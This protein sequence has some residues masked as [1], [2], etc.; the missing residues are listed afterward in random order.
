[1]GGGGG[2]RAQ[3][4]ESGVEGSKVGETRKVKP[5]STLF[6][7][8]EHKPIGQLRGCAM[9]A[10]SNI[11]SRLGALPRGSGSRYGIDIY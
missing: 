11:G 4:A 10:L 1:M 8:V 3:G 5:F 2:S 7:Q 6:P 9:S